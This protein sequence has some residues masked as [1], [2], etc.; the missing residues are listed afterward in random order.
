MKKL[1]IM[2][3]ALGI[4]AIANAASVNWT[5]NQ[6]YKPGT[7]TAASMLLFCFDSSTFSY[8]DAQAAV[9]AGKTDFLANALNPSGTASTAT[10][11][12]AANGIGTVENGSAM[13]GYMVI[14]DAATVADATKMVLTSEL[15]GTASGATGT[16]GKMSFGSLAAL[17]SNASNWQTV[18][19]PEPTSGLLMLLGIA[20]LA[21][22]RRRA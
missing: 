21:L 11:K 4:A 16:A 10:G 8:A 19:V 13:T 6:I 12:L 22:K 5:A 17:T 15:T 9:A 18:A 20:G 7:T 2:A 3:V 1:M 14:L